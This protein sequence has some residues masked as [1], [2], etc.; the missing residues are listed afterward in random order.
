MA[1]N[2][3]DQQAELAAPVKRQT[4]RVAVS[5]DYTLPLPDEIVEALSLEPGTVMEVTISAGCVEAGRVNEDDD[6]E[7]PPMPPPPPFEGSLRE[8]FH[9]WEDIQ[10]FIEEERRGWEKE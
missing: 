6:D 1:A 10:Q 7:L 8:Y 4:F 3:S 5:Q 2:R 9:G